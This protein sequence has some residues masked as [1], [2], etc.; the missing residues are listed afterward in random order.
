MIP[1]ESTWQLGCLERVASA[2]SKCHCVNNFGETEFVFLL[3]Y[4]AV[5]VRVIRCQMCLLV[6]DTRTV[7]SDTPCVCSHATGSKHIPHIY[8]RSSSAWY[9]MTQFCNIWYMYTDGE[10]H[11]RS[12]LLCFM[13]SFDAT[14]INCYT[15]NDARLWQQYANCSHYRSFWPNLSAHAISSSSVAAYPTLVHTDTSHAKFTRS[16]WNKS[17]LHLPLT[18]DRIFCLRACVLSFVRLLAYSLVRERA[19]KRL[20]FTRSSWS[21]EFHLHGSVTFVW[22]WN[23]FTYSRE[24]YDVTCVHVRLYL[25]SF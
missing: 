25:H 18:A 11:I 15:S 17:F 10:R 24:C 19:F 7:A 20:C 9:S 1:L 3:Y 6:L 21:T 5:R 8:A 4:N 23:I 22:N 14:Q 2:L 16:L 13:V 12:T